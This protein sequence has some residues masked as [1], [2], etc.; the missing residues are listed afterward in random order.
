[1]VG[2]W[3]WATGR[4][5]GLAPTSNFAGHTPFSALH[6]RSPIFSRCRCR[7]GLHEG[8]FRCDEYFCIAVLSFLTVSAFAQGTRQIN[9]VFNT[10]LTYNY[11]LAVEREVRAG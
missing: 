1:M 9:E 4:N 11:N 10:P 6:F 2:R 5:A 3:W 8:V 7:C